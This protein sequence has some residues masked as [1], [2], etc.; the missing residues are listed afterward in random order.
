MRMREEMWSDEMQC[1]ECKQE[2]A[3][4]L[5][6]SSPSPI[7]QTQCR[8]CSMSNVTHTKSQGCTGTTAS[9]TSAHTSAYAWHP[10]KDRGCLHANEISCVWSLLPSF[11]FL[12]IRWG[13]SYLHTRTVVQGFHKLCV[14]VVLS[15][16]DGGELTQPITWDRE[17]SE[18][19]CLLGHSVLS[20]SLAQW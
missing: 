5:A 18:A 19:L 10:R 9:R 1:D 16:G 4:M 7:E 17:T 3:S 12:L 15:P 11:S 20:A 14:Q 8:H 2:C 6:E 13:H